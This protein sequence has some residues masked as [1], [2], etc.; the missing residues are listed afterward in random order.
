MLATQDNPQ[1]A[2]TEEPFRYPRAHTTQI[3]SDCH[4]TPLSP[5]STRQGP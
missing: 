5:P 2:S 3:L 1:L 4:Q